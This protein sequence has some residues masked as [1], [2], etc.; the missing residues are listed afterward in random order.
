MKELRISSCKIQHFVDTGFCFKL[1]RFEKIAGA[2]WCSPV[3]LSWR[4]PLKNLWPSSKSSPKTFIPEEV[5]N[6]DTEF[7]PFDPLAT[8]KY[9]S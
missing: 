1:K 5:Q 7:V 3:I 4:R 8:H 9:D 2:F 6:E